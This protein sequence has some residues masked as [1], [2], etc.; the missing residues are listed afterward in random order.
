MSLFEWRQEMSLFEW[1]V[2]T[3]WHKSLVSSNRR[4]KVNQC[5]FSGYVV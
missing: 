3:S 2:S 4:Q 1:F 5:S